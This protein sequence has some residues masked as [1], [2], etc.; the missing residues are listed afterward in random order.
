MSDTYKKKIYG[1]TDDKAYELMESELIKD[2]ESTNELW[3][4]AEKIAK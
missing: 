4:N 1:G 2:N 3:Y